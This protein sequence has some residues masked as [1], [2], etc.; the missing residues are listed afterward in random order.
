MQDK[1]SQQHYV[2]SFKFAMRVILKCFHHKGK[3]ENGKHVMEMLISL[4]IFIIS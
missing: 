1:Y 2:V 4:V 3:E